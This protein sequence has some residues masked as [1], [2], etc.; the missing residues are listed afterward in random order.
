MN[1]TAPAAALDDALSLAAAA[2][3]AVKNPIA[4]LVAADAMLSI[5]CTDL[6][7]ATIIAKTAASITEPGTVTIAADRL[8]DLIAGFPRSA[9]VT[10]STTANSAMISCGNAK[11]RLPIHPIA[12]DTIAIDSE[13]ANIEIASR[14]LLDLL[15]VLP[16][17]GTEQSRFYL[18]GVHF[19]N[20]GDQLFAVATDGTKL[21]RASAAAGQLSLDRRL[22]LPAKSATTLSTLIKRAKPATVTLARSRSLF[23]VTCPAFSLTCRLIDGEYPDYQRVLPAASAN[24]AIVDRADMIS[25]VARMRA[26]ASTELPLVAL[27][28][29]ESGPLRMSLPQSGDAEDFLQAD[30]RGNTAVAVAVSQLAIMIGEFSSKRIELEA[31]G[32]NSPVLFRGDADKL[33]LL[34]SCR[35]DFENGK[36]PASFRSEATSTAS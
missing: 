27:S 14:D 35:W 15:A 19:H 29:E 13:I 1:I 24:V 11:Y 4:H 18:T 16:A 30:T 20:V 32:G 33:G 31:A 10:I 23:A 5:T 36:R 28:W 6:T 17:A 21:L 2:V 26:V 34:T 7:S 9:M 8:G 25:A 12:P 3:R 22:T